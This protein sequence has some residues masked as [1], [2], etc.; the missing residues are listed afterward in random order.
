[1]DALTHTRLAAASRRR[2]RLAGAG[3]ED[4]L[5]AAPGLMIL[6]VFV[7]VPVVSVFFISLTNW[8]IIGTPRFVGLANFARLVSDEVFRAAARNTLTYTFLLVPAITA[9]SFGTALLLNTRLRQAP[10]LKAIYVLP[11]VAGIV[12]TSNIWKGILTSF[13]PL[14]Q[15]LE[16]LRLPPVNFFST[17]LAIGSVS[18]TLLWRNFGYYALF[19]LAG[20]KG[21][22]R[23]IYDAA[24]VDGSVGWNTFRHITWPLLRPVTLLVV[25]LN[26]IGAFQIFAAVYILTAGGPANSTIS[27]LNY[28]YDSGWRFFRMGYA[29]AQAV[30]FFLILFTLSWMQRRYLGSETV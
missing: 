11:L 19:F 25:V 16:S 12:V 15:L 1:M 4:I 20:L 26:T 21:I 3:Y 24:Q 30:I 28:I 9:A 18:F 29:A 17:Q 14:N 7:L 8:P 13:G 23:E 6:A 5:L 27:L 22:D 2:S 10:A